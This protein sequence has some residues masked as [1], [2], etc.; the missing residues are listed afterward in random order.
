MKKEHF[1]LLVIGVIIIVA[2]FL[3]LDNLAKNFAKPI[4]QIPVVLETENQEK[5]ENELIKEENLNQEEVI[6]PPPF[7]EDNPENGDIKSERE[8]ILI[9]PTEGEIITSPLIIEGEARGSWFFEASLPIK[10]YTEDGELLVAHYGEAQ[11]DWMTTDFVSFKSTLVFETEAERGYLVIAKDNPSGLP[12]Y[13]AS[14]T[15]SVRF[16]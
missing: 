11:S 13:D 6:I 3:R 14:N 12:E 8:V 5:L 15:F 4:E 9:K 2:V 16:K 7:I 1:L 10:L